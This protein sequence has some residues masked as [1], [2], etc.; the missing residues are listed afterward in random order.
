MLRANHQADP[1]ASDDH[2]SRAPYFIDS[3]TPVSARADIENCLN[4]AKS[5]L[6]LDDGY[7]MDEARNFFVLCAPESQRASMLTTAAMQHVLAKHPSLKGR[8]VEVG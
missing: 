7:D 3:S 4:C 6:A 8:A 1:A 2:E 5:L